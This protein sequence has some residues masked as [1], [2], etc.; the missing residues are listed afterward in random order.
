MIKGNSILI[1]AVVFLVYGSMSCTYHTNPGDL[2]NVMPPPEA[3]YVGTTRCKGCHDGIY[4]TYK[5]SGHPY[6][7]SKVTGGAAPEYP[8]TT[9]DFLP[10]SFS[11]GWNDVSYV[12]GGFAWKYN[13]IDKQGFIYTGDDAQYNFATNSTVPY[14]SEMAPGTKTFSCGQCHTTGW[15]SAEDGA[16][17]QDGL[18]GMGGSFFAA[19]VQCEACHGMGGVHAS[20]RSPADIVIDTDA[21][22]C[23]QCH[24]RNEGLSISASDGFILNYSQYDELL[25]AKHKDLSCVSCH[26]P[27]ASVKHGIAEG[28]ASSCTECHPNMKNP[29]HNGADCVTC[30]MPNASRSASTSPNKYV[31]DVKTHIF[32]INPAANGQ[33]FNEDGKVANGAKGVTLSYACYQC[34][35]DKDNIG[36]NN[37]KKLLQQLSKK[38]TNYHK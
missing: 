22:A 29:T 15:E 11:K 31:A 6:I 19:G 30:H 32:K 24:A 12:I 20:T 23:G 4:N 5:N 16:V 14:H 9:V 1:I 13:L 37:S 28:I 18:V 17:P 26:N 25:A 35:K 27:H 36:G 38:A 3:G 34:H 10:P 2:P 33:M 21:S 7:L 8:S